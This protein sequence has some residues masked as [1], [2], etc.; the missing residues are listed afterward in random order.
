MTSTK[1]G[2][3]T[4]AAFAVLVFL[5]AAAKPA[6]A[7][8]LS[9]DTIGL[10]PKNVGE[11]AYADLKKARTMKWFPAL[12]EQM[13][14]ERFRQFEKFLASAGIDPNSQVDEL[15]WGLIPDS[16][17]KADD[18]KSTDVPS[19]EQIVGVALGNYNP[20][21]TEAFFKQQKLPTISKRGYTLFAFGSGAGPND[22]FFFFIDSSKAAFGHRQQLEKLIEIRYGGE[23]GL[24]RNDKMYALINEI[25]GSGVVWAVL[26]AGYTHLAMGQ[27]AP[28][29]QQFPD[30]AKLLQRMDAM[31]ISA[32]AS[33]GLEGK[34]QAVCAS[35]EDANTLS[36]L[37]TAG[38]LYKKYQAAKDNPDLGQL[39]DQTSVT[40][41]GDRLLIRMNVTDDQMAA[42]IRKNTFAFKM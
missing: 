25:N 22:L 15:A 21:S 42:L 37:M 7:G 3:R 5:S 31:I 23:E 12:Q 38:L 18:G 32:T 30:A 10:F 36:Q 4:L 27:L 29:V 16:T 14:P 1:I 6:K 11:F 41:S 17:A 26:D 2:L 9:A 34:F 33:S 8:S 19:S 35:P 24:L 40:P 20:S 39:L 28:E 13:L